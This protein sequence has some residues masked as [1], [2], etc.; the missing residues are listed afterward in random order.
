MICI[1]SSI[2]TVAISIPNAGWV[3]PLLLLIQ[4][5]DTDGIA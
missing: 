3:G 5:Q 4:I 2:L 1:Q